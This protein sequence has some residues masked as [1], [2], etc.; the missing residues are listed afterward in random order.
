MIKR[1]I[2]EEV[3]KNEEKENNKEDHVQK[4]IQ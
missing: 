1:K 4:V 3:K 2:M